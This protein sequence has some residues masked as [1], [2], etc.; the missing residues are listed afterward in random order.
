MNQDKFYLVSFYGI[1]DWEKGRPNK[2]CSRRYLFSS[3]EKATAFVRRRTDSP[4]WVS[5]PP[6]GEGSIGYCVRR[7]RADGFSIRAIVVD[8]GD[9]E[10]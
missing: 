1:P 9:G 2:I 8:E 5:F 7:D 3:M 10:A 4:E 6:K